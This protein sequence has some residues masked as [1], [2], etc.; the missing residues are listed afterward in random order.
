MKANHPHLQVRRLSR[1]PAA[2]SIPVGFGLMGLSNAGEGMTM[3]RH[4]HLQMR[5]SLPSAAVVSVR[6]DYAPM[7][8]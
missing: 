1:L 5:P 3:G 8:A 7:A 6:V 2:L 4:H